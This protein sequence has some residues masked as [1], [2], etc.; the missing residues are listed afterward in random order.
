ME[1]RITAYIHVRIIV[2]STLAQWCIAR[3]EGHCLDIQTLNYLLH[4]YLLHIP[5]PDHAKAGPRIVCR[6]FFLG[7][8]HPGFRFVWNISHR[9]RR[10]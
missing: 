8:V 6:T 1:K 4:V 2:R 10:K 5:M 7:T 3:P 9:D